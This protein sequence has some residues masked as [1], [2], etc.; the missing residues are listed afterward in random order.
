MSMGISPAKSRVTRASNKKS[1][2]SKRGTER[3]KSA[4]SIDTNELTDM[5]RKEDLTLYK[6]AQK[7]NGMNVSGSAQADLNMV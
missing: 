7:F 5:D 3:R 6:N 4:S 1:K 2:D